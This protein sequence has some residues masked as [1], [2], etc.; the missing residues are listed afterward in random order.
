MKVE[1][2]WFYYFVKVILW[3]VSSDFLMNLDYDGMGILK[4]ELCCNK[5]IYGLI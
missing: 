1:P 3:Y 4:K 2:E 5:Q